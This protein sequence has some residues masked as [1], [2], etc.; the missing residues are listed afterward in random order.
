MGRKKGRIYRASRVTGD[1]GEHGDG[2]GR[3]TEDPFNWGPPLPL[4][5]HL[6]S[7]V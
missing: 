4:R 1:G 2:E 6:M 3:G 7:F 5:I